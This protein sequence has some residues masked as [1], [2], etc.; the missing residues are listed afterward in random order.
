[1][2]PLLLL[3]LAADPKLEPDPDA[4]VRNASELSAALESVKQPLPE[5]VRKVIAAGK[6]SDVEAALEPHVFLATTINPEGR[7]KIARGAAD[8][9]LKA[10][11]PMYAIVKVENQSGGQQKLT[12]HGTYAGSAESPFDVRFETVGKITPELVGRLTEYRLLRISCSTTGKR[13]LTIGF[14]A[15]QGT[16]DLGFRG[17]VPVLFEV[18]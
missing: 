17:V 3:T 2:L 10:G 18:K 8:A 11:R 13:E 6:A 9:A 7:V 16:Q 5:A 1:M 4:L 15:G 12:A 14:D